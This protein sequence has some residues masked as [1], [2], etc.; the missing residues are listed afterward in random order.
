MWLCSNSNNQ[1][2]VILLNSSN[3]NSVKPGNRDMKLMKQFNIFSL[4]ITYNLHK[5]SNTNQAMGYL[6]ILC[7]QYTV[8]FPLF[9][10]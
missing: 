8:Y 9:I 7:Y 2:I 10:S 6:K 5:T 3:P 4:N 1:S